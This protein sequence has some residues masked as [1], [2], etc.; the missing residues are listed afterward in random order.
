MK[1]NERSLVLIRRFEGFRAKAYR[2]AAGVW[3]I[4]YGHTSRAGPPK[5]SP[6]MRITKKQAEDIL[7]ADLEKFAA[8]VMPLVNHPLNANQCGALVSFAYNVGLG[9]FQRSSV[10]RAVNEGR[11]S[12]VPDRLMRWTR[13]GGRRLR[14][15]ARRRRSEGRLFMTPVL[16]K[17]QN[18]QPPDIPPLSPRQGRKPAPRPVFSWGLLHRLFDVFFRLW[19]N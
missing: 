8:G 2:D 5:V 10:L 13:A 7:C 11:L 16:Q 19:R 1:M 15:L 18:P 3:T 6:G 12:D 14:G 4:G 9:N 17:P